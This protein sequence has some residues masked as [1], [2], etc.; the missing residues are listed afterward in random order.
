MDIPYL[1]YLF[2][3]I[4]MDGLAQTIYNTLN[5]IVASQTEVRAEKNR[6]I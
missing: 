4:F 2:I 6:F 5:Y 3:F 1:C